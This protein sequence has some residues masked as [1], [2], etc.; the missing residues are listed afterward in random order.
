VKRALVRAG[1]LGPALLLLI[2]VNCKGEKKTEPAVA[3]TIVPNSATSISGVAGT[4]VSPAPSVIV[5]DQN[6]NPMGGATV[7]FAVVSGG[8]SVT[9]PTATTD[10]SGIAA[11]AWTLGATAGAN[12][13]TASLGSLTVTFN[14]TGAAGAPAS[15]TK[16]AGD[17]QTANTGTTV[18]VAPSVIVK[19][20]NGNVKSDVVVTFA[21]G[22][23]GGSVTGGTA[24]SNAAGVATVGSWTL[25]PTPGANTLVASAA[26]VPSVTFNATATSAACSVRTDHTFGATSSGTL[27]ATDCQFSD[28][29]FVDFFT[30]TI[31]TAG[32]YIF[33]QAATFDAYLLLAFPDGATIAENDNET[34]TG[35]NSGIKALLPAGSY[36]LA[37]GSLSPGVTGDYTIS[38]STTSTNVGNCELVFGAK[39]IST[40]QN[41]EA[42]DCL[43]TPPPAAP[44]Y[45]DAIFIFLRAGQ[46]VTLNMTSSAVDSYL[47]LVR[48]DGQT[49]AQNDN[50]DATTKDAR[51]TYTAAQTNYYAIFARTAVASQTGAYTLSIQ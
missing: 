5:R 22:V 4:A 35:K 14:A 25:G 26:G 49:V 36:L 10:A 45:A 17:G 3:T 31:P 13:L 20:A 6:G 51:I 11:G 43:W 40:D 47:D 19:D 50:T 2:Y 39:G 48:L 24:T 38:T 44:I 23:G 42:T 8:G 7:T 18:P 32:A 33:R 41:I 27:S 12:V 46:S 34:E 29:S 28:G 1:K 15:L 16:S 9:P 21:A 30:T 37:P